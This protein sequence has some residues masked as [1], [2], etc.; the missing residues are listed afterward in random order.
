MWLRSKAARPAAPSV[1][2]IRGAA[3]G[4][5]VASR[6]T[7]ERARKLSLEQRGVALMTS[8]GALVGFGLVIA[9]VPSS[10]GTL[11]LVRIYVFVA[12]IYLFL[13]FA[14]ALSVQSTG[15]IDE[16]AL[17]DLQTRVAKEDWYK[18]DR[19]EAER[20]VAAVALT[21]LESLRSVNDI[22]ATAVNRALELETRGLAALAFAALVRV[23]SL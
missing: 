22:K 13:A 16:P 11:I 23:A 21:T 19:A 9:A 6:L 3:W 18:T 5:L 17:T 10:L 2:T 7:E 8:T 4:P 12:V 15:P 14:K 20:R 1:T